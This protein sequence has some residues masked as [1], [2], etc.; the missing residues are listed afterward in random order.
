MTLAQGFAF[1][2]VVAM[3]ALFA[4]GRLRYD[5]VAMLGHDAAVVADPS[6]ASI[7]ETS[8]EKSTGFGW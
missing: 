4:W 8:F 6:A 1:A 5:V 2:I 7:W 3:M